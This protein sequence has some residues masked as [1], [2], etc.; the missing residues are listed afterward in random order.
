MPKNP[1]VL[2][3]DDESAQLELLAGFLKKQG[4]ETCCA[5]SVA[6]AVE[7]F[8][9]RGFHVAV[10]DLKLP[11]G[12]GIELLRK[13]RD[14]DPALGA[15]ILTAYATISSATEGIRAGAEEFLE[16]PVELA[17]LENLLHHLV[18][19]R[20]IILENRA[21]TESASVNLPAEII[22]ESPE[23][24][25]VVNLVARVAPTDTP[26]LVT[27]ESGTGKELI[28]R[29]I[30]SGSNRSEKPFIPINCAAIPETL[31]ESELF[32]YEPGAFTGAKRR[33]PGKFELASGGTA[34]LDEVGDFPQSIQ[35]KLLRFLEDGTFFRL[36]G[37]ES[38][39]P[40]VR[41]I[42]A[43]NRDIDKMVE[44]GEFREDLFYRLNLIRIHIPPL[45]KRPEDILAI[46][47]IALVGFA[48]K[49]KK[50]IKG[51]TDDARDKFLRYPW[52]G[53]VR[54]LRN[55]IERAVIL[56]RSELIKS[57]LIPDEISR[58][59]AGNPLSVVRNPLSVVRN[60]SSVPAPQS[61]EQ[62]SV[63]ASPLHRTLAEIEKEH[64]TKVLR[65]C[66]G[67][68][69]ETAKIL[70]IHR[71]TLRNK[72]REYGIIEE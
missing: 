67:N 6:E 71:N 50:A 68:Q 69:T 1:T 57:E 25:E 9:K 59:D 14:I 46:A 63:N 33:Q 30:H 66:D 40:D 2:I 55:V 53:N 70:D 22:A 17:Q 61:D 43:T 60:P 31:L 42:S 20:E 62:Q 28:A 23:M 4:F 7:I 19:R 24:K 11:D 41:I 8:T 56:S 21:L 39:H 44:S 18:E 15:V 45:R 58:D 12:D 13:L 72:L 3:V 5:G 26:V 54:E 34:F 35:A 10:L 32:G 16:K 51:F 29:L 36:G 64:I 49:H 27:G 38:V 65:S 47:R 48:R 37:T 52:F